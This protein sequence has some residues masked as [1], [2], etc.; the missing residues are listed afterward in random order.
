MSLQSKDLENLLDPKNSDISVS[1][2]VQFSHS[3]MSESLRP[4]GLQHARL[5]CPSP[6]PGACANSSRVTTMQVHHVRIQHED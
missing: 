4:H 2:S 5:P 3:I 6:T 1:R